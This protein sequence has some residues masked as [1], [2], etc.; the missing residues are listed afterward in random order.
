MNFP[1]GVLDKRGDDDEFSFMSV[2]RK[3]RIRLIDYIYE[4]GMILRSQ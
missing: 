1:I 3:R 2:C 4:L